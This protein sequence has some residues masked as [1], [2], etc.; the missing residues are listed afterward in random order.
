MAYLAGLWA[1]LPGTPAWLCQQPAITWAGHPS[2]FH[3]LTLAVP[4][5]GCRCPVAESGPWAGHS[6]PPRSG[7]EI[8]SPA[9]PS[10]ALSTVGHVL[11]GAGPGWDLRFGTG[12]LLAHK[13]RCLRALAL[14]SPVE[15]SGLYRS[16]QG[17]VLRPSTAR[18][19]RSLGRQELGQ[20]LR[21]RPRRSL[22]SWARCGCPKRAIPL[23]CFIVGGRVV[24]FYGQPLNQSAARGNTFERAWVGVHPSAARLE[25]AS[26]SDT[27]KFL[28][29]MLMWEFSSF[30]SHP[31]SEVGAVGL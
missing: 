29:V 20:A 12:L 26:P 23:T 18:G 6:I 10:P 1:E 4:H 5:L 15:A 28:A 27:E 31:V 16:L 13:S 24:F 21:L 30:Q 22:G 8:M 14:H 17:S 7:R 25:P 2:S 11:S 9:C 3:F 19:G